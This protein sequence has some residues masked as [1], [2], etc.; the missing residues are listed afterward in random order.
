MGTTGAPSGAQIRSSRGGPMSK[1]ALKD[2]EYLF[3][4]GCAGSYDDRQKKVSRALVKILRAGRHLLHPRRGGD[5]NGDSAA[6]FGTV[7]VPG[8]AQQNVET[9]NRYP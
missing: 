4:V 5:C 1:E 8:L 7:P 3:F 6:G 9:L 2:V